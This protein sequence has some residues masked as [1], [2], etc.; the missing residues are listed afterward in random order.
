MTRAA[1]MLQEQL[2]AYL[3]GMNGLHALDWSETDYQALGQLAS[4]ALQAGRTRDAK[5]LYAFLCRL[6]PLTADGFLGLGAC[7]QNES[8]YTRAVAAYGQAAILDLDDPRPSFHAAQCLFRLGQF[9]KAAHALSAAKTQAEQSPAYRDLRQKIAR[10]T[11]AVQEFQN[12]QQ[13]KKE[14]ADERA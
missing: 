3:R 4:Q 13:A 10:L 2:S 14:S 1:D 9:G 11:A 5:H 8:D 7:C 6:D 12:S